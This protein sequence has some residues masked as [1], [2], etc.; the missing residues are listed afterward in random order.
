M[1]EHSISEKEKD[2]IIKNEI[3]ELNKIMG[4]LEEDKKIYAERLINQAAFMYA[5]L[6]ELQEK[7]NENGAIT[8]FEQGSQKMWRENPASKT[9]NTMI[10]NYTKIIKQIGEL[11]PSEE[12][13]DELMDFLKKRKR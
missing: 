8:W 7:I 10:R 1:N 4:N 3:E 9:Y 13:S 6:E 12:G 2:R 5:T 11:I